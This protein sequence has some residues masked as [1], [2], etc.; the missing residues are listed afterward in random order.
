VTDGLIFDIRRFSVHDGPGIRT[1]V[2]FKGCPLQ[3]WWCHNPE[4]QEFKSEHSVKKRHM[5]GR[6][7]LQNETTGKFMSVSDVLGEVIRDRLFYDESGGGVTLSG[8]EPMMQEGFLFSLLSGARKEGVHTCVD[9]SGYA[10][11]QAIAHISPL[12]D[13]FLYDLKIMDESLHRHYTGVSNKTILL[14]LDFLLRA[15]KKVI[16]RF[17]VIPEITNT[18]PNISDIIQFLA[19]YRP[20]LSYPLE[21]NLLP[22]HAMA[23]GKYQR[24]GKDNKLQGLPALQAGELIPIRRA[25]EEAGLTVKI[26]G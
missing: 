18:P 7:F 8:G 23:K 25:F 21:I 19:P 6:E 3:C 16:I 20:I 2:F 11:K 1:T 14:N 22:Y 5:A 12:T 24:F 15:G 17:P 9:T 10:N 26:G 13:L 4:S